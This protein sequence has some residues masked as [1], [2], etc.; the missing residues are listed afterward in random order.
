MRVEN[1][2]T[3]EFRPWMIETA[4]DYIQASRVLFRQDLPGPGWVNAALGLEI[5]LKSFLADVDGPPG[6]LGEQYSFDRKKVQGDGHS[7]LALFDAIPADVRRQLDFERYRSWIE[8]YFQRPFCDKRYP[9]ESTATAGY[10]DVLTDIGEEMLAIVIEAYKSLG[11][12][13]PWIVQY[14]KVYAER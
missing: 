3:I 2:S 12:T 5:L 7:L 10:S 11:C 13:D 9:Y 1:M 8:D 14:P 6:G 4:S